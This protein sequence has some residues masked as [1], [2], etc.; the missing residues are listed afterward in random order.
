MGMPPQQQ[1]QQPKEQ[2]QE[3]VTWEGFTGQNTQP[4]R[5]GIDDAQLYISDG[6]CPIGT[7]YLRTM[8]DIGDPVFRTGVGFPSLAGVGY[9]DFFT[10]LMGGVVTSYAVIVTMD[11]AVWSLNTTT[12]YLA[13]IAPAGT[14]QNPSPGQVAMAAWGSQYVL[15]ITNQTN[16]YFMWDGT[17]FFSGGDT[18]PALGGVVPTGL[19]GTA[20]TTYQGRVWIAAGNN[21]FF[22]AP[23]SPIDF[24]TADGG[25]AFTSND[26]TLRVSFVQLVASN[27][28]LFLIG[29]SSIEYI[30]G[31]QTSG[32]PPTTTFTVTNADPEI[33]TSW[34]DSVTVLGSNIIFANAWGVHVSYGGRT[35]KVSGEMDGIYNSVPSFGGFILSAAKHI[36]YGK[37]VFLLLVL[38]VDQYT[39]VQTKKLMMWD[40]KKW[41]TQPL[42]V[43]MQFIQYQEVNSVLT[44]YGTDGVNI[45]PLLVKPNTALQKVAQSKLWAIQGAYATIKAVGRLWGAAQFFSPAAPAIT[46]SIDSEQGASPETLQLV[47]PLAVWYNNTPAPVSWT[48]NVSAVVTWSQTGTGLILF[49]PQAAA[50]NGALLGFT[51][52]TNAADVALLSLSMQPVVVQGRF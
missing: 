44:A 51:V 14:I 9:F 20:L 18:V 38:V 31:V 15:F 52:T 37:R 8:P 1:A 48:N 46:V 33:G 7:N 5:V 43:D 24:A 16:G 36:L 27:G 26:S 6:F 35:A 40:E 34:G 32:S 45:Y 11:G 25:G 47:A 17:T 12:L 50:Q 2:N 23:A 13:L 30:A 21:I 41:F 19:Y 3:I 10:L 22:S 4:S 29:D 39:G 49:P 42:G 28:Y